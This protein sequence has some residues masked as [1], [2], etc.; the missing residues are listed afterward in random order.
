MKRRFAFLLL[1]LST[2]ACATVQ[3]REFEIRAINDDEQPVKCLIIVDRKWPLEGDE[4]TYTD[5]AIR[6]TFAAGTI[7][8]IRV[9]PVATGADGSVARAPG[10]D[11][12]GPYLS[13]ERDLRRNDPRV[14][15]FILRRDPDYEGQ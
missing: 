3:T 4:L 11:D 10:P 6:T 2:A 9:K 12:A 5:G 13:D 7:V 15:L 8:N 1:A 14:Q